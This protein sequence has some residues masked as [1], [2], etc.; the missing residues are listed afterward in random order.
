MKKQLKSKLELIHFLSKRSNELLKI[1][2]HSILEID[3]VHIEVIQIEVKKNK[4][5]E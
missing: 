2:N 5:D 3:D 4:K 1:E